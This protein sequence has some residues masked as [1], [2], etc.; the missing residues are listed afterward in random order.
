MMPEEIVNQIGNI[1]N[2]MSL[3][4]LQT[5]LIYFVLPFLAIILISRFVLRIR[6]GLL[7]VIWYI[8]AIAGLYLFVSR[9]LPNMTEVYSSII[10]K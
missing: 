10:N 3:V 4:I 7:K 6:G 1:F 8:A 2:S 9:G 5:L